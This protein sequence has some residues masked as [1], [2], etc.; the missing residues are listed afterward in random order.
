V[1]A[2]L[3]ARV[4]AEATRRG[5]LLAPVPPSALGKRP[6]TFTGKWRESRGPTIGLAATLAMI[7]VLVLLTAP[8]GSPFVGGN[9]NPRDLAEVMH[10]G[11]G[12]PS[13]AIG[14]KS[15]PS[16][17]PQGSGLVSA[18][19]TDSDWVNVTNGIPNGPP[20][21]SNASAVYDPNGSFL[22][23]FGGQIGPIPLNDTWMFAN[24]AWTQIHTRN[25]PVAR[26]GAGI[27]Y[28][29]TDGYVVLFGG[30]T[31]S[32][33]SGVILVNVTWDF[34][35]K[36]WHHLG[37]TTPPR[38]R[39]FPSFAF[40]P[41]LNAIILFGGLLPTNQSAETWE[42]VGMIWTPITTGAPNQPPP[43]VAGSLAFDNGTH[44]LV[45][46]GGWDPETA[47]PLLLN[48]TWVYDENASEPNASSWMP[49][50]TPANLTPRYDA[51]IAFDPTLNATV[52]FGGEGANGP[53]NDTWL[54]NGTAWDPATGSGP[55]PNPRSGD[56]LS[57]CPT[58]GEAGVSPTLATV[59]LGGTLAPGVLAVDVWFFGDLPLSV[60]PPTVSPKQSDTGYPGTLSVFAFGGRS[61]TYSYVWQQLPPGCASQNLPQFSCTPSTSANTPFQVS[62]T[63]RNSSGAT[64]TSPA[65][66]WS[67]NA[68]PS[69][70]LFTALPSPTPA[71]SQLT[72]TVL[73]SGG[74]NPL[75]FQYTGLPAG[76]SSIDAAQFN[77]T[78]KMPGN[79]SLRVQITDAD[80]H[81]ADGS[82]ALRV[83]DPLTSGSD[84]WAYA[85]EGA[86]IAVLAIVLIEVARRKRRGRGGPTSS[87]T[88]TSGGSKP[89]SGVRPWDESKVSPPAEGPAYDEGQPK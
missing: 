48:D 3:P 21:R 62:V 7:I 51:A 40:D 65:A 1:T 27:T 29:Q 9:S 49:A 81:T 4:E 34:Y 74:T 73:F 44:Q 58:P 71:G 68:L 16:A 76:C 20:P 52:L 86:V 54:W 72:V 13:S 30:A 60:L 5:P 45:M 57:E 17:L 61:P 64:V 66:P 85:V 26:F 88:R 63:V 67:V 33:P 46:F 78:P 6:M 38:G 22:L 47:T 28:D 55:S 25:S 36:N 14:T 70:T 35:G 31:S 50:S 41:N 42:L 59:L 24:G 8:A 18:G 37:T 80:G 77:C 2:V 87:A 10:G 69:V 56:V 43:R 82:T 12:S 83:G 53:L 39:S 89:S 32:G 79:Y 11:S 75:T 84:L 15:T 19:S 23:L